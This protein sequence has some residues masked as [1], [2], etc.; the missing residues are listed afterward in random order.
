MLGFVFYETSFGPDCVIELQKN[1]QRF[2]ILLAFVISSYENEVGQ[3]VS[4][5]QRATNTCVKL[6]EAAWFTCHMLAR[7]CWLYSMP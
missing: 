2:T 6:I 5:T 3:L 4:W 7:N 1:R